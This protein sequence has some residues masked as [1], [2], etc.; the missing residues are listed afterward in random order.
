MNPASVDI[1]DILQSNVSLGLT[2]L[3][4][5]FVGREP[6]SPDNCVTIYDTPGFPPMLTLDVVDYFYP[7]VQILVRNRSYTDGWDLIDSIK[8]ALH[9]LNHEVWN[10]TTYEVIACVGE[11]GL[12]DWDQSNRVHFVANFNIQRS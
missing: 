10:A 9:G 5:L 12:L 2:F 8:T 1:R 4:N 7:S 11:P 6:T 3:T